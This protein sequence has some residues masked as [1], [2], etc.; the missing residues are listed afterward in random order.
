MLPK[1][2][3]QEKKIHLRDYAQAVLR[4]K[5]I[6][7]VSFVTLVTTVTIFSFK[8][9]PIYQATTQVMIDKE[10]PNVVSFQEVMSLNIDS[11]DLMFYQTQYKILASRSLAQRIINSLNLKDSPE[12]KPDEESM[13]F[14]IGGILGSLVKKLSPEKKTHGIDKGSDKDGENPKLNENFGLIIILEDW[15]SHQ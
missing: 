12:F 6:V 1:Q 8:A 15:L 5:W 7:I 13:G 4:R 14:S 10:N 9:T 3:I 2:Y 11:R